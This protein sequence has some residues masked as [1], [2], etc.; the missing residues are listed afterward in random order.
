MNRWWL[1]SLLCVVTGCGQVTPPPAFSAQSL[2][3]GDIQL[4]PDQP[5]EQ[6][7]W[8]DVPA[9]TVITIWPYALWDQA[10]CHADWPSVITLLGTSFEAPY[11]PCDQTAYDT[12]LRAAVAHY[13]TKVAAWQIVATPAQQD[14]PFANY[15][16]SA[17]SYSDV[18]VHTAQTLHAVDATALVMLGE[19]NTTTPDSV[20][21]FSD[22]LARSTVQ[23]QLDL[24]SASAG[25]ATEGE[26]L[27]SLLEQTGWTKPVWIVGEDKMFYT[28][29]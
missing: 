28:S 1:V 14:P 26:V 27:A 5:A 4:T 3:W 12:W 7:V 9:D 17:S 25:I 15:I 13:Q 2:V 23:T 10:T 20:I 29:L 16:G 19:M 6:W 11:P 8:P 24:F 22:L 21:W 18:A